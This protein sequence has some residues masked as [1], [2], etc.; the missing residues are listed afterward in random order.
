MKAKTVLVLSHAGVSGKNPFS[1][2]PDP[3]ALSRAI[4]SIHEQGLTFDLVV[5]APCR[6][7]HVTAEALAKGVKF[8]PISM[9]NQEG[10][11][12][13]DVRGFFDDLGMFPDHEQIERHPLVSRFDTLAESVG[14]EV[15]SLVEAHKPYSALVIL[16]PPITNLLIHHLCNVHGETTEGR[17]SARISLTTDRFYSCQGALLSNIYSHPDK[18]LLHYHLRFPFGS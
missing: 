14:W 15:D 3:T 16:F 4:K 6:P 12:M 18:D 8:A 2:E 1:G 11:L 5:G 7:V 10:S 17:E 9:L 13:K